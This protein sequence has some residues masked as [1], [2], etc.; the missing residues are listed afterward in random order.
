MGKNRNK[1]QLMRTKWKKQGQTG[2]LI[3]PTTSLLLGVSDMKNSRYLL[4]QSQR[5]DS[6]KLKEGID[7][8]KEGRHREL[9]WLWPYTTQVR[10]ASR[11]L[12]PIQTS[13]YCYTSTFQISVKFLSQTRADQNDQI[14]A[15]TNCSPH[16]NTKLNHQ[17]HQKKKGHLHKNQ[18]AGE[19]S[20]YPV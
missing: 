5:Q 6:E 16:G 10:Q 18:K 14:E 8:E 20:Q 13:G 4:P 17:P 15:T 9:A 2:T 12:G 7:R 1:G 19:L 3:S 11:L